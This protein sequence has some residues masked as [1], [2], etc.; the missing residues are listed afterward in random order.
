MN[1]RSHLLQLH[2][3]N[4][5]MM[6]ECSSTGAWQSEYQQ[7]TVLLYILTDK[8]P[9]RRHLKSWREEGCTDPMNV[10]CGNLDAN[11]PVVHLEDVQGSLLGADVALARERGHG[12]GVPE[13]EQRQVVTQSS[14]HVEL[15]GW[16]TADEA[17]V[18]KNQS[19]ANQLWCILSEISD[20]CRSPEVYAGGEL[21]FRSVSGQEGEKTRSWRRKG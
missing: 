8:G 14:V 5:R 2:I 18:D 17:R 21:C 4:F 7:H 3:S 13:L 9:G 11:V 15:R 16:R 12:D 20:L 6:S 1:N 19:S 10:P